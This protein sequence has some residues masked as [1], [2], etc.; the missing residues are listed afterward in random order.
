M[1]LGVSCHTL[2]PPRF[3]P[4]SQGRIKE[5]K[6]Q[7]PSQKAQQVDT[8]RLGDPLMRP[9]KVRCILLLVQ[10][11]SLSDSSRTEVVRMW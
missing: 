7:K 11:S 2:A 9:K 1:G 4:G 10:P 5:A 3:V 6:R 8:K